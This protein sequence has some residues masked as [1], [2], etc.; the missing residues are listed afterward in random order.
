MGRRRGG[1]GGWSGWHDG[2]WV[3]RKEEREGEGRG[4][5]GVQGGGEG[6]GAGG[7]ELMADEFG[8]VHGGETVGGLGVRQ[9]WGGTGGEGGGVRVSRR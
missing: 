9:G 4:W 5:D 7:R 8:D 2:W 1:G 6:R 3:G